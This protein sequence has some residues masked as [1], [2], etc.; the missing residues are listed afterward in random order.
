[1]SIGH[2]NGQVSGVVSG[3]RGG[4]GGG[5]GGGSLTGNS[6]GVSGAVGVT[7]GGSSNSI[8]FSTGDSCNN[9]LSSLTSS[10]PFNHFSSNMDL[11]FEFFPSSTL[12]LDSSSGWASADRPHSR[13]SGPPNSRP[14]S[15]PTPTSPSP[16]GAYSSNTAVASH[17]SPFHAYSPTS[18]NAAHSFSNTFPFSPLQESQTSLSNPAGGIINANGGGSVSGS[19][20]TGSI[21]GPST[22]KRHDDPK[23][24][25]SNTTSSHNTHSVNHDGSASTG[26][27][28][29]GQSSQNR[30][31]QNSV[32][33][34]ESGR[35]RNLLTKKGP[36]VS[37]EPQDN[38]NNDNDTQNEHRILKILLNQQDEDE[39][40]SEHNNKVRTSPSNAA[41]PNIEHSKSSLGNN[42]L[43]QVKFFASTVSTV[44]SGFPYS[45]EI[46]NRRSHKI[47]RSLRGDSAGSLTLALGRMDGLLLRSQSR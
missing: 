17:C 34:T 47:F 9:P 31:T 24:C 4:G 3:G 30:E 12:D 8:A 45:L 44:L 23:G 33:S 13:E 25:P 26:S 42:M 1:M 35:L 28:V 16:Q 19:S 22:S 43:L 20:A 11:E 6:A 29:T 21:G 36:S 14:P 18:V 27:T 40:H 10:N 46:F 5:G 41:K 7:G 32:V 15:Q 39:Y 2:V 38:P 37:D